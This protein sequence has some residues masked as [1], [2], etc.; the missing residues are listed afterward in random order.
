MSVI[1]IVCV[2]S[3][4]GI[5]KNG[6]IPWTNNTDRT[7]YKSI[8]N[9][10]DNAVLIMGVNTWNT[11]PVYK[12]DKFK[13]VVITSGKTEMKQKRLTPETFTNIED[14]LNAHKGEYVFLIGG[15]SIYEKGAKY[16]DFFFISR[17]EQNYDC[18]ISLD[19]DFI[20][21]KSVFSKH[22][23]KNYNGL[24]FN[25]YSNHEYKFNSLT[26]VVNQ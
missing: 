25:L 20:Y 6:N 14:A 7:L 16:S 17:L 21:D 26:E 9:M 19:L 12:G 3:N 13:Y 18:D 8:I 1:S 2:D 22:Y 15:K 23:Y 11:S 10:Y 5:S 4:N 24:V